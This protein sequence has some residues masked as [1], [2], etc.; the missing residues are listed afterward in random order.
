MDC[1]YVSPVRST[2]GLLGQGQGFSVEAIVVSKVTDPFKWAPAPPTGYWSVCNLKE[3][4]VCTGLRT[5]RSRVW[6]WRDSVCKSSQHHSLGHFQLNSTSVCLDRDELHFVLNHHQQPFTFP[7][8]L[9][10]RDTLSPSLCLSLVIPSSL[11]EPISWLHGL[12]QAP[13]VTHKVKL[14]KVLSDPISYCWRHHGMV[15]L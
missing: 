14:T 12:Q 4:L 11:V 9:T 2:R 5:A 6:T 3:S 7:R 13:H 15:Y 10:V 1:A 8:G